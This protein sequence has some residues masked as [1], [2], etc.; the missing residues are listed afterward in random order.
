M[1]WNSINYFLN[2]LNSN[3]H[4]LLVFVEKVYF[5]KTAF[6]YWLSLIFF[7]FFAPR[8]YLNNKNSNFKICRSKFTFG[9]VP[10]SKPFWDLNP[11]AKSGM[12]FCWITCAN[13]KVFWSYFVWR[14]ETHHLMNHLQ[15]DQH[16]MNH[17]QDDHHLMNQLFQINYSNESS[18]NG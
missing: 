3:L 18:L 15:D 14:I 12:N 17:L 13:G 10:K 4:D 5:A 8:W 9:W 1:T 2:S 7:I 16:L 6:I 11:V